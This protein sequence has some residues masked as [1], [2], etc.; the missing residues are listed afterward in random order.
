VEQTAARQQNATI[1]LQA[2]SQKARKSAPSLLHLKAIKRDDF[3]KH[4][5]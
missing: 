5:A 4:R 1:Q 2:A 3:L